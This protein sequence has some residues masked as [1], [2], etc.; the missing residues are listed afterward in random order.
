MATVRPR[1][2]DYDYQQLVTG[3]SAKTLTARMPKAVLQTLLTEFLDIREE[4]LKLR[5]SYVNKFNDVL[6]PKM[7]LRYYQ[8]ENK[9]EAIV[10]HDMARG[11]PL[12]R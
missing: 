2:R 5:K 3:T 9:L 6:S 11:I 8:V 10:R 7:V 12:V 4:R 1:L